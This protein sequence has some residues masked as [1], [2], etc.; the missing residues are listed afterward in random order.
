MNART[1]DLNGIIELALNEADWPQCSWATAF[2]ESKDCPTM[3]SVPQYNVTMS[4]IYQRFRERNLCNH[5]DYQ[6][7]GV[8][9]ARTGEGVA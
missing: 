3:Y 7:I 6:N 4:S 1:F 2:R 8:N 9:G 5:R